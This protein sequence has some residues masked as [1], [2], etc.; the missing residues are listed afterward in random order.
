VTTRLHPFRYA[1]CL[2]PLIA[3]CG[4]SEDD[5]SGESTPIPEPTGTQGLPSPSDNGGGGS[6]GQLPPPANTTGEV[7]DNIPLNGTI[8]CEVAKTISENC[9]TCHGATPKFNAPMS[10][11]QPSDFAAMSPNANTLVMNAAA[12]RINAEAPRTMPPPGTVGPLEAAEL[13]ALTAW[14]NAGAQ[15]VADGCAITEPSASGVLQP[16]PEGSGAVLEPYEGWDADVE[17]YPF[18]ANAG[19]K[20]TPYS[21]GA[22]VDGYV[23]FGFMPPW[24]G[25]RY[26]RAFRQVIDNAQ[27]LHHWL[28]FELAGPTEDGGVSPQLGA[29]PDGQLMHGWAPGGGDA[30]YTPDVGMAMDSAKGYLLELHYNST[31]SSAKD[32][33]GVEICVTERPPTNIATVSWLGTDAISG[34]SSSGTCR[35]RATQPIRIISGSPHMHLKGRHM[36]VTVTRANG[37]QEVVHDEAFDFENQRI[38]PE[39][40]T[41]QPGDSITTQCDFSAPSTFGK[42]T[43]DEMCYWFATSY[44]PGA[45]ADGAFFGTLVHGDGACLGQ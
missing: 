30:Y 21:V 41:L 43:N 29:H 14:L 17:C 24:Q 32:K 44:P 23:G 9:T 4:S 6:N 20:T 8:P 31:D 45:L 34:T 10:L 3:G 19:D 12:Q 42:G 5:P 1:I 35:P 39:D 40:I 25:T 37:T 15:P 38:Y 13:S 33:S 11:M 27:V 7:P 26:V 22:V 16:L 28:L 18:V 36:K 2:F